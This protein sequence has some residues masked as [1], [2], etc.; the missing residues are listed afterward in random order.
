MIIKL[1]YKYE[2]TIEITKDRYL[3][4]YYLYIAYSLIIAC[5]LYIVTFGLNI[6]SL[7]V[8]GL[9]INIGIALADVANDKQMCLIEREHNL[10][11]K[12]Q[13]IQWAS[14]SVCSL[15]VSLLGAYLAST[16]PEPLNYKLAYGICIIIPI[17]ALI[18]LRT[19]YFEEPVKEVKKFT[20]SVFRYLK[21]KDFLLGLAFIV[22]LRFSPSFGTGLMIK[23]R[24]ELFIGKMFLGYVGAL[25]TVVGMV[26]YGLYYWKAHKFPIKKMLYFTIVFGAITSLFYLYLPSKWFLVAYSLLFGA[27][28]GISFLAVMSFMVKILPTGSEAMFYALVTSANNLSSRLGSA[29]GGI[30]YDNFGYN[31]N[32]VVASL[33]T[34][35]CIFI[36]PH[37]KIEEIPNE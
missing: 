16:L 14:L 13:A 2:V 9:L 23:C 10:K 5:I 20:L 25:G 3:S 35:L 6:V 21:N 7:I 19:K 28:E 1:P 30:I 17:S 8:T 4:K 11:G 22:L 18:Y 15:V 29:F 32:V 26:G 12:V 36:I 34:F 27:F 33:C 31:M 37:L 24:E